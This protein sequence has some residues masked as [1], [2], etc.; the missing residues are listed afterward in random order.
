[1]GESETMQFSVT[2]RR[3]LSQLDQNVFC[4]MCAGQAGVLFVI[5]LCPKVFRWRLTGI[6]NNFPLAIALLQSSRFLFFS[7]RLI[8]RGLPRIWVPPFL[9]PEQLEELTLNWLRCGDGP[10]KFESF[11]KTLLA[12][13][14]R[15]KIFISIGAQVLF[16][17]HGDSNGTLKKLL[18]ALASL[19]SLLPGKTSNQTPFTKTRQRHDWENFILNPFHSH[20]CCTA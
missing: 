11:P 1:M 4:L 10:R 17:S 14:Q 6:W 5:N 20:A 18:L 3:Y 16:V 9:L 8:G 19:E 7:E 2:S 12:C 15:H 13:K